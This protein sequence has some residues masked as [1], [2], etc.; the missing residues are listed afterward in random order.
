MIAADPAIEPIL[1]L[2]HPGLKGSGGRR[3]NCSVNL[4]FGFKKKAPEI[5]P[6]E[7]PWLKQ[8]SPGLTAQY[9]SYCVM[10]P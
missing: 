8:P 2:C 3:S 1:S 9:V 6:Q 10:P 7:A 5:A 4:V